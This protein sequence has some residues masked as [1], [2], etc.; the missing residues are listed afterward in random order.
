[1]GEY[2]VLDSD[3]LRLYVIYRYE[4]QEINITER[5]IQEYKILMEFIGKPVHVS[6]CQ[7]KKLYKKYCFFRAI[8]MNPRFR[9][10]PSELIY[11]FFDAREGSN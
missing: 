8:K 7:I 2:K 1:M 10:I 3:F 4:V 9:H 5:D 11:G 6:D